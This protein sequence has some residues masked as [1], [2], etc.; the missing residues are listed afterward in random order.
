MIPPACRDAIGQLR[1]LIALADCGPSNVGAGRVV[2]LPFFAVD[3]GTI[4]AVTLPQRQASSRYNTLIITSPS[5][6]SRKEV[7]SSDRDVSNRFLRMGP[8]RLCPRPL[9]V[10]HGAVTRVTA[11]EQVLNHRVDAADGFVL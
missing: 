4:H 6:V 10:N 3:I 1:L 11:T 8:V 5:S 2:G 7:P 9:G